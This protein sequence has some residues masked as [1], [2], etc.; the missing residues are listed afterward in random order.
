MDVQKKGA[1]RTQGDFR[2]GD[3]FAENGSQLSWPLPWPARLIIAVDGKG[4]IRLP[5]GFGIATL[6]SV[7]DGALFWTDTF[8]TGLCSRLAFDRRNHKYSLVHIGNLL[9]A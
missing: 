2:P 4:D 7:A 1:M 6:S 8:G 9:D 3:I 5:A